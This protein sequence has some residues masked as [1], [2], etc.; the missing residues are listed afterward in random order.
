MKLENKV[1]NLESVNI[2]NIVYFKKKYKLIY[3]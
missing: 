1:E 2:I 3:N